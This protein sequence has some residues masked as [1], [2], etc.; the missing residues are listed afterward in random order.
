MP[1]SGN[2]LERCR[3]RMR[4]KEN[5]REGEAPQGNSRYF[6]ERERKGRGNTTPFLRGRKTARCKRA[7]TFPCQRKPLGAASGA[8]KRFRSRPEKG[9]AGEKAR[10]REEFPRRPRVG[11]RVPKSQNALGKGLVEREG[12]ALRDLPDK[13]KKRRH[14]SWSERKSST[15]K[16]NRRKTKLGTQCSKERTAF[17]HSSVV[18]I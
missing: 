10:K 18:A 5:Q 2:S 14:A 17:M 6:G 11:G 7:G 12:F 13:E 15:A 8:T 9:G 4:K 16:S 3:A 1:F